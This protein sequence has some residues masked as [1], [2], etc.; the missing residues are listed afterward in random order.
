MHNIM[1]SED[2]RLAK[3]IVMGQQE[4]E[5]ENWTKE[6]ERIGKEYNIDMDKVTEKKKS[7]WKREIKDKIEKEIEGMWIQKAKSMK[8]MRHVKEGKFGK[9]KYMME[10]TT[11]EAAEYMRLRLEMKD[12]GNNHGKER[13]CIC[14]EE[15][16]IEHVIE[17]KIVKKKIRGTVCMKNIRSEEKAMLEEMRKWINRYIEM[18][19]QEERK[20]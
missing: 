14:G 4:I 10:S 6:T 16:I 11:E 15:E 18:R 8:K 2:S 20:E 17:C 12:L 1:N 3:R 7:K 5:G 19:E 13:K 9:R